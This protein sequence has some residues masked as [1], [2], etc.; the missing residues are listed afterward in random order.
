M[1]N[2]VGTTVYPFLSP[3]F[4]LPAEK[5]P[6]SAQSVE[7]MLHNNKPDYMTTSHRRLPGFELFSITTLDPQ[8]P[9]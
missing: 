2:I 1:Y 9:G 3:T 8:G 7:D 5:I 6:S 4:L